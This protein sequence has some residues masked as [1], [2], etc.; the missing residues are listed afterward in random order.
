MYGPLVAKHWK[1]F[2]SSTNIFLVFFCTKVHIEAF[3]LPCT[4]FAICLYEG[5]CKG[6]SVSLTPAKGDQWR[7]IGK[8]GT[9]PDFPTH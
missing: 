2:K 9:F 1:N 3:Y 6:R 5:I 8:L 4:L 7:E